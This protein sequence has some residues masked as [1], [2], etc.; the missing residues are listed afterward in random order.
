MMLLCCHPAIPEESRIVLTLKT[1]GGFSVDEIA[2]AFLVQSSAIAQ[3]LVR[4]KRLI[5]D[6]KLT[7]D[8][9]PRATA[10]AACR[11][12]DD[13]PLPDVQRG[14]RRDCR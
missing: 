7:F 6:E 2:R 8:F 5:R 14:L 3:R 4:A 10:R 1:L 11:I 12:A 13:G 9:P